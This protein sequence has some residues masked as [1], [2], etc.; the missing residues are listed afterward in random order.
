MAATAKPLSDPFSIEHQRQF[1]AAA[2]R[3]MHQKR[4]TTHDLSG[5]LG[6]SRPRITQILN[7]NTPLTVANAL[8]LAKVLGL[9]LGRGG[10]L[11]EMAQFADVLV[12]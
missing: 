11:P 7:L 8:W 3:A 2:R 4:L 6:V 10:L 5:M 1:C 12:A 9:Q